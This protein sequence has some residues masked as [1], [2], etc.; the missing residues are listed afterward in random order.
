MSLKVTM[1]QSPNLELHFSS[2]PPVI[3][4]DACSSLKSQW[5]NALLAKLL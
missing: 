1:L 5:I 3:V 2:K 4:R